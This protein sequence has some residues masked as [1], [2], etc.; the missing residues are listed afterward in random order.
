[1][2]CVKNMTM[3]IS[4]FGRPETFQRRVSGDVVPLIKLS[5]DCHAAVRD[6]G[7]EDHVH[8]PIRE[9]SP[10][11]PGHDAL[12][13]FGVMILGR[14]RRGEISRWPGYFVMTLGYLDELS[15]EI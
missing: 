14:D 11:W 6:D 13:C 9:C 5:F 12:V 2:L 7:R 8:L 4:T 1:M 3:L 10:V 15:E